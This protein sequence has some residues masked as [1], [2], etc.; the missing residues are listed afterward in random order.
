MLKILPAVAVA[1]ARATRQRLDEPEQLLIV[2]TAAPPKARAATMR[3]PTK[4]CRGFPRRPEVA[5]AAGT[6]LGQPGPRPPPQAAAVLGDLQKYLYIQRSNEIK[7][8][9]AGTL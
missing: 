2:I 5:A 8:R 6:P 9:P 7:S 3:E 1:A 4:E